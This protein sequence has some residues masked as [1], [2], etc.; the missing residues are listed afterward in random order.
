MTSTGI[1]GS[2]LYTSTSTLTSSMAAST[3]LETGTTTTSTPP[4]S[5][6]HA[7]PISSRTRTT[8][9][10]STSIICGGS[11]ADS[12]GASPIMSGAAKRQP[13][14]YDSH[15]RQ[16]PAV[17]GRLLDKEFCY[18]RKDMNRYKVQ[19]GQK[20]YRVKV[21]VTVPQYCDPSGKCC[22][23]KAKQEAGK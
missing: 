4:P 12:A 15:M 20:F 19:R 14:F 8:S 23:K 9:S 17:I 3:T 16:T 1:S 10:S 18:A 2:C 22:S 7:S 21:G 11:G 6:L 5:L 13:L